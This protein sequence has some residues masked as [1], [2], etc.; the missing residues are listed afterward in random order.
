MIPGRNPGHQTASRGKGRA[1]GVLARR[2]DSWAAI[3]TAA[4]SLGTFA[5]AVLKPPLSGP[6]CAGDCIQYPFTDLAKRVPLDFLWLWPAL[7]IAPGFSAVMAVV[8]DRAPSDPRRFSRTGLALAP[9]AAAVLSAAYFVRL[10]TVQTAVLRGETVGLELWSQYN[11]HGVFIA[12][13]EAGYFLMAAAF[14][15]AVL[16]SRSRGTAGLSGRCA[17]PLPGDSRWCWRRSPTT[18]SPS[19]WPSSTASRLPPSAW[20]G[21][22]SSPPGRC[23]GSCTA[24]RGRAVAVFHTFWALG[25]SHP[26]SPGAEPAR[27]SAYTPSRYDPRPHLRVVRLG[28]RL[29]GERPSST[30][31]SHHDSA[32]GSPP[33]SGSSNGN[34][35]TASV[36][37]IQSPERS[38]LK[39][40]ISRFDAA[41]PS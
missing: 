39:L 20:T 21:P 1:D 29:R 17:G 3:L 19:G 35:P 12:L 16:T 27:R 24:S 34:G 14:L 4:V 30:A 31:D 32:S 36:R 25:L 5:I 38:P 22:W 37:G 2:F 26:R 9:M 40:P 41:K 10:R 15:F 18:P 6:F 11:P 33:S 13:E 23:L 28:K 8:H 7:L